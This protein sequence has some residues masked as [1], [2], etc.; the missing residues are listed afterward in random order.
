MKIV[1]AKIHHKLAVLA[2]A[3]VSS[4][5]AANELTLIGRTKFIATPGEGV[6]VNSRSYYTSKDDRTLKSFHNLQSRSDTADVAF[7]R[8]SND[9]GQTWSEPITVATQRKTAQGILRSYPRIGYS[10]PKTGVLIEFWLSGVLPTDDPLEG[11]QHWSLRYRLSRD[12]GRSSFHEGPVIQSSQPYS[13]EHP[14]PGVHIGKNSI[15]IGDQSCLTTTLSNGNLLQPVQITPVGPNGEYHNPGG[16]YTYHDAAVLIGQWNAQ[17]LIDWTIS[18]RVVGDPQ[19]STRGMLEPTVVEFPDQRVLMVLRGSNQSKPELPAHK[20]FCISKDHGH[21]WSDPQPWTYHDG[22]P[23]FSPSSCSQLL[24]H[25]NGSIYWI[26]NLCE[27]NPNG[28]RPRYPLVIGQVDAESL[29]LM[30]ETIC[31]IDDRRE[32]DSERLQ[33]SNFFARED[34]V[35]H[36]IVVHC[37]P[38][39][40]STRPDAEGRFVTNW[41]ADAWLYR[42]SVAPKQ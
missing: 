39:E 12:G 37:S 20:W 1:Q 4:T 14:F 17:G 30:R 22:T 32:G 5:A 7:Q 11:M 8:F 42:L 28:N 6:R 34:R 41:T 13:A 36:D 21:T 27:S 31:A 35:T 38:F 23:F 19:R 9:N 29:Q 25:S 16:G 26:G 33:V 2:V 24:K 40:Y 18:Q 15:M 10:D 3:M